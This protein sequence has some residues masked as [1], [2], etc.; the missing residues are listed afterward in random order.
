MWN[1]LSTSLY[2]I[3]DSALGDLIKFLRTAKYYTKSLLNENDHAE[4]LHLG[5]HKVWFYA[6]DTSFLVS[7]KT[8]YAYILTI[9]HKV[10]I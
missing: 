5:P 10:S 1:I 8:P 6:N 9:V 2:R 4:W 3:Q 7:E